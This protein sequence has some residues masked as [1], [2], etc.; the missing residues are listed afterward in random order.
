MIDFTGLKDYAKKVK[1]TNN[2]MRYPT[3]D[4]LFSLNTTYAKKWLKFS[5][6]IDAE[7]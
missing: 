6:V 4:I 2:S 5:N 7:K 1:S 3:I